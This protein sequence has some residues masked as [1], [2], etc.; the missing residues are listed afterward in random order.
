MNTQQLHCFLCAA[1]RLNFTKAAEELYLTP[2]TV[3]HTIKTLEAELKTA[4]F[5]RTSKK[6]QLTKAGMEFYHDAKEILA[7]IELAEKRILKIAHKETSCLHIGCTS[8]AELK[9]LKPVLSAL[10]LQMPSVYPK[11]VTE[12]YFTLKK[13]FDDGRL[14]CMFCTGNMLKKN[15]N[16]VFMPL[17]T[18]HNY[19]IFHDSL[20]LPRKEEYFFS[21]LA[22]QKLILLHPKLVPFENKD[23]IRAQFSAHGLEHFDILCE[24]DRTGIFLAE[25]GYGVCIVPEF[26]IP[27]TVQGVNIYPFEQRRYTFEYGMAF[28]KDMRKAGLQFLAKHLHL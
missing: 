23:E 13:M 16:C 22:G 18:V 27:D 20:N 8:F 7:K 11:I 10:V 21:D 26:C 2:P 1:D 17:K 9:Y 28:S 15:E 5:E 25:C 6:V 4:L 19:V 24:N 14:D 12:D 3:T